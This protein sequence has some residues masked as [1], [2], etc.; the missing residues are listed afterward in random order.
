MRTRRNITA[1]AENSRPEGTADPL[2]PDHCICKGLG[3][4]RVE[5]DLGHPWFGKAFPCI[6]TLAQHEKRYSAWLWQEARLPDGFREASME[7]FNVA[8]PDNARVKAAAVRFITGEIETPWLCLIGS[9][10]NGKTHVLCAIVRSFAG[11]GVHAVYAYVPAMLKE[12]QGAIDPTTATARYTE[13]FAAYQR[14]SVLALDD[15]GVEQSTEW[16]RATMEELVDYRYRECL[17]TVISTN[18]DISDLSPRIARRI[19]DRR[20]CT[21][22]VNTAPAWNNRSTEKGRI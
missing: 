4:Y 21:V 13:V 16:S 3:W 19:G 6:C 8:H 15:L 14:S 10:G 17:P 9:Y 2:P 11:R 18:R 20:M 22:V 7:T 1:R 12:I 5:V